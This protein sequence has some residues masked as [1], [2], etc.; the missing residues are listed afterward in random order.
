MYTSISNEKSLL[1]TNLKIAEKKLISREEKIHK[2][3]ENYVAARTKQN[4]YKN[5]I[6]Q[7]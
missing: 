4:E 7:I 5:I 2:I 3:E 6:K 1:K